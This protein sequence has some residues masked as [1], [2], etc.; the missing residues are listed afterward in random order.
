MNFTKFNKFSGVGDKVSIKVGKLTVTARIERDDDMGPPWKVHDGHG[1]V[2]EWRPRDSKRPGERVLNEDRGS[3]RFYDWQEAVKIAKRDGW[4]FLPY[5][6]VIEKDSDKYPCGGR[7]TAGPFTAYDAEEFNRAIHDV[8]KQHRA[9][10]TAGQNAEDAVQR[11]FDNLRGWCNDDWCWVGV[12]LSV[13]KGGV[14]LDVHAAS[15][16]GIESEAGDYFN[17]VANELLEEAVKVG[18][19][20]LVELVA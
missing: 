7:A 1:P 14:T 19:D 4:G 5:E 11:D 12:V 16:W 6:L 2:S 9:T 8:Y 13:S 17:E 15:L 20:R 18:E 3:C 10:M